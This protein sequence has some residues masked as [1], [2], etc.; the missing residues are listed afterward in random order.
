L[1]PKTIHFIWIDSPLPDWAA[2]NIEEFRRLNPEHEIK[3]HGSDA[4]CDEYR[5]LCTPDEHASTRSDLIRYGILE[6]EGGWYFDV[7]YWP[8]RPVSDIESAFQLDGSE[9]FCGWMNN[10]RINNG[11]LACGPGLPLWRTLSGWIRAGGVTGACG[12]RTKYGPRLI[13]QLRERHPNWVCDAAWPWLHGIKDTEAGKVYRRLLRGA[14]AR[15]KRSIVPEL[16]GAI[17]FAFHLWAHTHTGCI[18]GGIQSDNV[19]RCTGESNKRLI[20]VCGIRPEKNRLDEQRPWNKIADAAAEL[21]FR[22]E[23]VDYRK[24][25]ALEELSDVPEC[26]F[27]WNGITGVHGKHSAYADKLQVPKVILEYGFWRRNEYFQADTVGNQHRSSWAESTSEPAPPDGA[28]RLAEF[29]PDGVVPVTAKKDGYIL[30][31]GQVPNDSQLAESEIQSPLLLQR[32]VRAAMPKSVD[33]YFRPHPQCSNVTVPA[34]KLVLPLLS[35]VSGE[36]ANEY[37]KSKTG[38]GLAEAMAGARFVITI[39]STA[40]NEALA[41]GVPVLAFGPAL[42][43]SGAGVAKRTTLATLAADIR[44]MLDGWCPDPDAVRNYLEW[45]ASRQYHNEEFGDKRLIARLLESAGVEV[46]QCC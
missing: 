37:R 41:A 13:T 34:H 29:Y 45:L 39:N 26:L 21:G 14:S 28:A 33:A 5:P 6:R 19:F 22:C 24:D 15:V 43:T 44:A 18:T 38:L 17:P 40:G 32:R 10:P 7:D 3:L 4:I 46:P 42:Y 25:G 23:V 12:G 1:I 2:R 36:A 8:L 20:A 30:V 9:L 35:P 11:V 27:L 16:N 31:I